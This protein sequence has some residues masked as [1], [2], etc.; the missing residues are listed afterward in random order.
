MFLLVTVSY[1]FLPFLAVLVRYRLLPFLAVLARYRFLLFLDVF[2]NNHNIEQQPTHA[3]C[4]N[5]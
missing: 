1:R 2:N 3:H 5:V 4:V